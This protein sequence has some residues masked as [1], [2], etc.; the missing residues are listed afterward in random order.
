METKS[1]GVLIP[2]LEEGIT[3]AV[4]KNKKDTIK[5]LENSYQNIHLVFKKYYQNQ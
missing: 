2:Q 4:F 3:I 5:A 1:N